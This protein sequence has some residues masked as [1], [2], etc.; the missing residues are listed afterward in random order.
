MTRS[1]TKA[2]A[3]ALAGEIRLVRI[4]PGEY[5]VTGKPG[6]LITRHSDIVIPAYPRRLW[7][8]SFSATVYH[9]KT[10]K[11]ALLEIKSRWMEI[12]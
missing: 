3:R 1:E 4:K 2:I 5:K 6:Y 11:D 12:M 8:I 10:L 7:R 9:A